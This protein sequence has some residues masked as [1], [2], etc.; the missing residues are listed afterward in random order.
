MILSKF[1]KINLRYSEVKKE[2]LVINVKS[3]VSGSIVWGIPFILLTLMKK[4]LIFALK[5]LKK[6]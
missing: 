1:G 6:G 4:D 2:H 5:Q 3:V